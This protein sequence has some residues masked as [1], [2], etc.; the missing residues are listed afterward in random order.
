MYRISVY[1]YVCRIYTYT[2]HR[3]DPTS[4]S[5]HSLGF[6]LDRCCF[7]ETNATQEPCEELGMSYSFSDL[8]KNKKHF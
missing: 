2:V 6:P 4:G 7:P 8:K 3:L 5:P 1:I